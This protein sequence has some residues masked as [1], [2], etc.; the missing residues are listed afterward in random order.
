MAAARGK[1][2]MHW[3]CRMCRQLVCGEADLE[4]HQRGM[5][6]H[7]YY[8]RGGSKPCSSLFLSEPLPWMEDQV[9]MGGFEGKIVCP[10]PRCGAKLGAWNWAGAQCSCGTWV[11]PALQ[12]VMSKL[13]EVPPATEQLAAVAVLMVVVR[14]ARRGATSCQ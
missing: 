2:Q 14:W 6:D 1:P 3:R 7:S 13:D 5:H 12:L 4:S 10:T 8:Q 9:A 11:T